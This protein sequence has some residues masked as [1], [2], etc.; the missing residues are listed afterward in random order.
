[1]PVEE[2]PINIDM[3][4]IQQQGG[5]IIDQRFAGN[6]LV[7]GRQ[8]RSIVANYLQRNSLHL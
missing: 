8:V 3:G 7:Q 6:E 5:P 1:L 2:G 4:I